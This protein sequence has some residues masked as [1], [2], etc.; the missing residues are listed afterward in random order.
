MHRRTFLLTLVAAATTFIPLPSLAAK[1]KKK[2]NNN[3]DAAE[4]R[5]RAKANAARV[6]ARTKEFLLL[7]KDRN[8]FLIGDE[9]PKGDAKLDRNGDLKLSRSEFSR[10]NTKAKAKPEAKKKK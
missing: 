5:A 2:K 3:R 10:G 4:A 7:D 1:K 9:I 6:K 8:G